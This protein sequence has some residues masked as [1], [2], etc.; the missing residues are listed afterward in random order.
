MYSRLSVQL[1]AHGAENITSSRL[2]IFSAPFADAFCV[3]DQFT[4]SVDFAKR[5]E[6]RDFWRTARQDE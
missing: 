5:A 4:L 3:M 1:G 6:D 2:V